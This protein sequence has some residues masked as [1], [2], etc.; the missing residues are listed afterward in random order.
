MGI[1]VGIALAIFL[2][3]N[4][5]KPWEKD[6]LNSP[7]IEIVAFADSVLP[8]DSMRLVVRLEALSLRYPEFFIPSQP[9]GDWRDDLVP[10]LLDPEVQDLYADV[11]LTQNEKPALRNDALEKS[12][13]DGFDHY[14]A[15]MGGINCTPCIPKNKRIFTYISRNEPDMVLMGKGDPVRIFIP[16]DR[17]MGTEHP[18]YAR[19]YRYL[20]KRHEPENAAVEVFKALAEAYHIPALQSNQTLLDGMIREAK[21]ILFIQAVLG[22]D[23]AKRALGYS[24]AEMD[25]MEENEQEL[26][27]LFISERLLYNDREELKRKVLLPAPFSKFG[28][29]K[30]QEI[31]GKAGVWF[32]WQI[33]MKYW[34]ENPTISLQ[35]I[36]SNQD[37]NSIFQKSGYRP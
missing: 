24:K 22:E 25:F 11:V 17:Y 23:A 4:Q 16:L 33:L 19:E 32:G 35:D 28:T 10:Y 9:G 31:P 34:Q 13:Q 36:L 3:S 1:A 18:A 20:I 6:P 15:H 21:V 37:A 27:G 29:P 30:D 2:W 5:K 8:L 26:W 7:K 14:Y 12:L